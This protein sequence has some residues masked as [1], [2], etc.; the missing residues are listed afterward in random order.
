MLK[1]NAGKAPE[2]NRCNS[3]DKQREAELQAA[4]TTERLNHDDTDRPMKE[5]IRKEPVKNHVMYYAVFQERVEFRRF[6]YDR[7]GG[8]RIDEE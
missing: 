7:R 8:S 3:F 4:G 6:L 1:M 2:Q 5:E